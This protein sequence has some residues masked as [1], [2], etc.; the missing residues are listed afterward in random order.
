MAQNRLEK[1]FPQPKSFKIVSLAL[2]N[3]EKHILEPK[4]VPKKFL[5]LEM[6]KKNYFWV[7]NGLE[8]VFNRPKCRKK[9]FKTS[10][11]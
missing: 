5:G 1:I 7:Q 2:K 8:K 9:T 3:F 4:T 10:F 11:L 6:A